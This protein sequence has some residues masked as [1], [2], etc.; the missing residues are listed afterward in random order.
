[1]ILVCE[2]IH[3]RVIPAPASEQVI[4]ALA[5]ANVAVTVVDDLCGFAARRDPRLKGLG[6]ASPSIIV[7][8]RPRAIRWLLHASGFVSPPA[9]PRLFDLRLAS[10]ETILVAAQESQACT[11]F[12]NAEASRQT[13]PPDD[14]WNP[15]F[16]V[17]D[18]DR[19]A[20]CRQCVS[21]CPFGVYKAGS[22]GV[23]VTAPRNCKDNC[24]A[25][26]RMCPHR[27]IIFPKV[28]EA[29]IDGSSVVE[30]VADGHA[31]GQPPAHATPPGDLHGILAKRKLRLKGQSGIRS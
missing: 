4:G 13:A 25:C 26:A 22:E 15:W 24:P 1:M 23:A 16:P 27:A 28:D 14:S 5:A 12:A 20:E 10:L 19:C 2:C 18:Y 7:A 9:A 29:P 30:A 6:D 3:R 8:C 17:I 21:F 31:R 11:P